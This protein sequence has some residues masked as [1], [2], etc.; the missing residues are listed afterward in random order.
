MPGTSQACAR[1]GLPRATSDGPDRRRRLC[2]AVSSPCPARRSRRAALERAAN[3]PR[4]VVRVV[5]F[6]G[7]GGDRVRVYAVGEHVAVAI[8]DLAALCGRLDRA[9]CCR[10]ARAIRSAWSMTCRKKS[11]ASIP[12]VQHAKNAGAHEQAERASSSRQSAGRGAAAAAAPRGP[13][14]PAAP[15]RHDSAPAAG[16]PPTPSCLRTVLAVSAPRRS[17]SRGGRRRHPLD[18][19]CLIP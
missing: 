14:R 3:L 6:G 16:R 8:D 4:H 18:D 17:T 1:A 2:G 15:G 9:S 11:R 13:K 5:D 19:D 7:I 10:S 12:T